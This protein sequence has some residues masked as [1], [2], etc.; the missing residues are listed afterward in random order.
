MSEGCLFCRIAAGEIPAKLVYED[1]DV[2]AF[3]DINPQAPTHILIIP[4][5][6]IASVND[7]E[8]GDA[9]LVGRLYLAARELAE[10][11]GIAKSGYR[12]VLNTGPGAGQTVDHI[13]LHLLGGRPLHWPPG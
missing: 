4:R 2:V 7:L 6:H 13:H 11:E 3:R 10:R 1:D 12:L 5:R 8:A 9:E